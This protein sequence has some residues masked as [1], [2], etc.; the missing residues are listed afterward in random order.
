MAASPLSQKRAVPRVE[1]E[2][3]SREKISDVFTGV[4]SGAP[5]PEAGHVLLFDENGRY[6][7]DENRSYVAAKN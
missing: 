7:I 6:L 2:N 1:I 3:L 4:L 5:K